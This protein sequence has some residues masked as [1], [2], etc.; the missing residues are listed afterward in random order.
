MIKVSKSL[1]WNLG[2]TS[3]NIDQNQLIITVFIS[4]NSNLVSNIDNED[5][6]GKINSHKSEVDIVYVETSVSL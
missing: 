4:E 2:K 1:V 3:P 5:E 6:I